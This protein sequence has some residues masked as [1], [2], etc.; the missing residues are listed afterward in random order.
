MANNMNKGQIS[1][2]VATIGGVLIAV[3]GWTSS[4]YGNISA[5]TAAVN[6]VKAETTEKINDVIVQ[7]QKADAIAGQSIT[8]N[9]AD[10]KN[11]GGRMG[12][13]G[14]SAFFLKHFV[15]FPAWSHIDMAGMMFDAI[16]NPY[17]P[18]GATGY[19]VRLLTEFV[20]RWAEKE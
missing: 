4:Y 3:I 5:Q 16:D 12:G 1:I 8:T 6:D 17:V 18:K 2:S 13:V 7:Y 9:T 19:G 15:D 14:T 11:T 20:Q 10:I